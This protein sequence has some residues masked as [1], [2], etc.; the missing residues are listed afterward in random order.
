MSFSLTAAQVEALAPDASAIAA[1]KKLG[2]PGPWRGLGQD[3][4]ALWGE[5][6]G[7]ALYQTRI[8]L[9]DYASNCSCPSR[10]LPC[11]HALGLLFLAST[12]AASVP[13]G[14]APEWVSSWLEKRTAAAEKK[15]EPREEKP[16]DEA[17]QRKRADKRHAS[18][19]AG[20]DVL[21]A[22]LADIVRMGFGRVRSEPP[23]FWDGQ[24]RRLVDAQAP[25]LAARVRAAGERIHAGEDWAERLLEDLGGIALVTHAYRRLAALDDATAADVRR[26]VGFSLD[27][28]EVIAHGD[29]EHDTW[30]VLCDVIEQEDRVRA[31][32]IW[33]R[34]ERSFRDAL[35]L[36]FS[37]GGG[38][39]PATF[40]SGTA[41]RGELAFYPGA[42]KQRALVVSREGDAQN[43]V[44]PLGVGIAQA[45]DG[46]AEA[47]GR[48]PFLERVLLVLAAVVPRRVRAEDR[49]RTHVMDAARD[50]LPLEGRVHDV[51]FALSGGRPVTLVGEWD[52]TALAPLVVFADGPRVALREQIA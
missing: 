6:Q 15:R 48:A 41:F 20:M 13:R 49:E 25:G 44:A 10:K 45:L 43:P 16:V 18:V 5:C 11:K 34:G 26:V 1:G 47:L 37:A 9:V 39:F 29:L 27:R 46:F 52:G 12:S 33:L 17:A 19:L 23:S 35:V 21:D 31:Q 24:A 2:K 14:A 50:T 28:A 42:V 38:P 7:S 30:H 3:D 8:A 22:W 32:R 51:L 4:H 36:Q 40:V